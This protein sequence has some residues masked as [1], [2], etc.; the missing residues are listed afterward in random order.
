MSEQR[1]FVFCVTY[2]IIFSALVGSIPVDF[3]GQG[4]T[5]DDVTPV[6]PSLLSDFAETEEYDK[7]DFTGT[8]VIRFVY[9]LPDVSGT[10]FECLYTSNTFL[11]GAHSLFLGVWLGGYSWI[12]FISGNGTNYGLSVS[13]TNIVNDAT[14]G[15]VRYNLQ[16][17]DSGLSAGGFV[18][19]WNTTTYSNDPSDAWD[20]DELFL[21][22]GVGF[23]AN[24]DITSLLF[25]LMLLQMP[26][27]PTL[28][29]VILVTPTWAA[30]IY[31]AWFIIKSMIPLLG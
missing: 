26:E 25:S 3:Q 19:Y 28:V 30:L 27:V 7:T 24:T 5:V 22:H 29:N 17:V 31:V 21:L 23:T 15:V 6:N 13:F 9:D 12:N 1:T 2:I 20:N 16:Y 10:T 4:S 18:F 14:D 8:P 11:L